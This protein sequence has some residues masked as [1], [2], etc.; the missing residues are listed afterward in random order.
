MLLKRWE[1]YGVAERLWVLPLHGSLTSHDQSK[2][3]TRH[4]GKRKIVV[5]TNVAEQV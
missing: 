1:H 2:V 5:S 4:Q 3:F